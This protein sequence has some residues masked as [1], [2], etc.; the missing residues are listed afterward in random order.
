M[1]IEN[2]QEVV[3]MSITFCPITETKNCKDR[4]NIKALRDSILSKN[5]PSKINSNNLNIPI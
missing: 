2:I 5:I 1:L 3:A 4:L